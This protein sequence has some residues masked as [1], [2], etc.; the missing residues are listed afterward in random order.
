MLARLV[1]VPSSLLSMEHYPFNL[2]NII[3]EVLANYSEPED[4]QT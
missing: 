3:Q 2:G 1:I 4:S